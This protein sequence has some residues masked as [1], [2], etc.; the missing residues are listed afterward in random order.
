[1]VRWI[2]P[3]ATSCKPI[4][5]HM[6]WSPTSGGEGA[7]N[8]RNG[9]RFPVDA[10]HDGSCGVLLEA[11]TGVA[12][13]VDERREIEAG[14]PSTVPEARMAGPLPRRNGFGFEGGGDDIVLSFGGKKVG[15][16]KSIKRLY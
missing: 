8:V 15:N 10:V 11:R 1:M 6:I 13:M 14:V 9:V 7:F 5:G 16:G 3:G 2:L 12:W 4:G